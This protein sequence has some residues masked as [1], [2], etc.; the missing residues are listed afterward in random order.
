M[1]RFTIR[2]LLLLTLVVAMAVGWGLSERRWR[3]G[4]WETKAKVLE[5]V[6]ESNGWEVEWRSEDMY[7]KK[8]GDDKARYFYRYGP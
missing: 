6:V 3:S 2:E 8:P 7:V 5:L 1:F 4:R